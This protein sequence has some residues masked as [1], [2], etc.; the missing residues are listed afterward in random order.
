MDVSFVRRLADDLAVGTIV[1]VGPEADSDPALYRSS[2]VVR[3]PPLP[4]GHLPRL[5]REAGVLIMPYADLPVTR[6]I[7]PLKLKEYLATGRP[8]VVRD[9][10]ATR[11]WGDCLDLT[12]SPEAFSRAVR[13]RFAEGLPPHQERAR[14]RL[15]VEGW[16]AK[17]R[18]FEGWALAPEVPAH[19]ACGHGPPGRSD[20]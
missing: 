1:L 11:P 9:L 12:D 18:A 13:Q 6:A 10:P 20:E 7:Q 19:S 4:F 3:V 5:A 16:A 14:N 2:R 17:A 8:V 15:A